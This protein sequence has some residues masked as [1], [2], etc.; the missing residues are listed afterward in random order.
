VTIVKR[1]V[2]GLPLT[3]AELDSNFT[4]LD[5]RATTNAAS[6]ATAATA[7]ATAST[8]AATAL[9]AANEAD[10]TADAAATLAGTKVSALADVAISGSLTLTAAAHAFRNVTY[11]GAAGI[12]TMGTGTEGA[13]IELSHNGTGTIAAPAAL[14]IPSGHKGTIEAGTTGQMKYTD[15][16]WRSLMLDPV[17]GSFSPVTVTGVGEVG[18]TLTATPSSGWLGS[19]QWQRDEVDIGGA[20][21]STRVLTGD[22]EGTDI[23]VRIG[24]ATFGFYSNEIAVGAEATGSIA[25]SAP[26][27]VTPLAIDTLGATSYHVQQNSGDI[28]AVGANGTLFGTEITDFARYGGAT[29]NNTLVGVTE[30]TWSSGAGTNGGVGRSFG[31]PT[32]ATT[33]QGVSFKVVATT[34]PHTLRLFLKGVLWPESGSINDDLKIRCTLEDDSADPVVHSTTGLG[35][36][37]YHLNVLFHAASTTTMLVEI[38]PGDAVDGAFIGYAGAALI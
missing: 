5:V 30:L 24:S 13:V 17:A 29:N 32:G 11:T 34:T 12:L 36:T 18:E 6:A 28:G 21:A 31:A 27:V 10:D 37:R 20:T 8:A 7:A 2:K 16:A 4:D 15:G 19:Y 23:R 3:H 22:D 33:E 26:T 38:Y 9:A 14:T 25:F 1:L 35:D